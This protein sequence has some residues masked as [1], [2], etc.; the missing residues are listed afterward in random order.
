MPLGGPFL[1]QTTIDSIRLWI[2]S[3]AAQ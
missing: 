3:G 1:A 2:A